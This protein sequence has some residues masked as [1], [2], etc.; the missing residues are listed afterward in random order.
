MNVFVSIDVFYLLVCVFYV[1]SFFFWFV[2]LVVLG[3]FDFF[4][5]LCNLSIFSVVFIDI[6]L[7]YFIK[8]Y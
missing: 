8:G 5:I 4:C 6:F 1:D 7:L 3:F 2:E